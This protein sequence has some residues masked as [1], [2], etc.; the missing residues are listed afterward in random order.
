MQLNGSAGANGVTSAPV[1]PAI[2]GGQVSTLAS[3]KDISAKVELYQK[4]SKVYG[5]VTYIQK[6]KRNAFHGYAYA[7]EAAI[8]DRL[9]EAF[10]EAGLIFLPPV[11]EEVKDEVREEKDKKPTVAT[12]IRVKFAIADIDT[13]EQIEGVLYGRGVDP[14]DK[15]IYKA[16]TGAL[17]YYLTTTFLI[18]TGDDPEAEDSDAPP[19]KGRRKPDSPHTPAQQAVVERKLAA[20]AQQ[21]Q[22]PAGP[23]RAQWF[24]LNRA[25]RIQSFRDMERI[26]PPDE[27]YK[28]LDA[29]GV[30]Q[31]DQFKSANTA[32]ACYQKLWHL[33]R[34]LRAKAADPRTFD[35]FKAG[36]A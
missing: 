32:W 15:G 16:L 1:L 28:I 25:E 23:D 36:V 35:H 19:P 34:E 24:G 21:P 10:R 6:D 29:H 9:H 30:G 12:T 18:P 33:E 20:G 14:L 31:P 17:K 26:L 7:S 5:A 8:K 27:V 11:I 22:P 13:G 2:N 4:I 3:P